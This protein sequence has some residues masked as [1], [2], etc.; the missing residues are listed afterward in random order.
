MYICSI[1]FLNFTFIPKGF[2]L[3]MAFWVESS[4]A[5]KILFYF[6]LTSTVYEE[7]SSH[8]NYCFSTSDALFFYGSFITLSSIFSKLTMMCLGMDFFGFILFRVA[9]L[10]EF[11]GLLF[12]SPNLVSHYFFK[13]FFSVL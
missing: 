9:E 2:L 6:L 7:K 1:A 4:L 12:L 10:L 11:V 8:S 5:N 13:Y 3:A